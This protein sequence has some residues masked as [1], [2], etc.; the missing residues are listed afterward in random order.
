MNVRMNMERNTKNTITA[1][2]MIPNMI[3]LNRL[4]LLN[5]DLISEYCDAALVNCEFPVTEYC[6]AITMLFRVSNNE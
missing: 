5:C 1:Q 2:N 4:Y 6:D 3:V